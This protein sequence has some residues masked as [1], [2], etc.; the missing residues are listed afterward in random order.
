MTSGAGHDAMIVAPKLSAAMIFLRSPGGISHHPDEAVL[1]E[2]VASALRVG[3]NFLDSFG[4]ISMPQRKASPT[5]ANLGL[6]RSV[7]QRESRAAYADSFIRTQFPGMGKAAAIVHAS[8]ALGAGFTQ[9]T[10]EMEAG[11]TLETCQYQRFVFVLEG[12]VEV[13]LGHKSS[14]W[15]G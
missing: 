6:T 8:P 14:R 7:R 3:M 1:V 5:L 15:E 10:A 13:E 2:D 9:Y 11:G 12:D 4:L